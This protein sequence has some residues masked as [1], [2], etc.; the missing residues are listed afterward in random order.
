M[1]HSNEVYTMTVG[2]LSYCK[3]AVHASFNVAN[4]PFAIIL[5]SSVVFFGFN[6]KKRARS[7]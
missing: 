4:T 1:Q 2:I 7:Y 3:N 5:C 6:Y